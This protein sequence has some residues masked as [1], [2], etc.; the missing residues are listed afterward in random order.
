MKASRPDFSVAL[1][2]FEQ[3][4]QAHHAAARHLG[5]HP[6]EHQGD[7]RAQQLRMKLASSS[8]TR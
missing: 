7:D 2:N 5:Q 3:G 4:E 1:S 6:A 8:R